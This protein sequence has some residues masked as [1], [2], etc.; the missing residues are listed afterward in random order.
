VAKTGTLE[1]RV[2]RPVAPAKPVPPPVQSTLEAEEIKIPAW[3]EPL[4]RN[5]A[6]PAPPEVEGKDEPVAVEEP[7]RVDAAD[8]PIAPVIRKT[9][10]TAKPA[11]PAAPVFSRTLLDESSA[12]PAK[13]ASGGNKSFLIV[14]AAAVILV[15]AAGGTWYARQSSGSAQNVSPVSAAPAASS[16]ANTSADVSSSQPTAR[17]ASLEVPPSRPESNAVPEIPASVSPSG[18][19]KAQPAILSERIAKTSPSNES[20]KAA[21]KSPEPE[22]EPSKPSLGEV[23]LAKPKMNRSGRNAAAGV[24]E[25]TLEA[26]GDPALDGAAFGGGLLAEGSAQPM[27]PAAPLVVGGDV[28]PARLISSVPPIYPSLAKTQHISG[29]VRVDAL[30][31]ANGRVSAMKVVSGPT[32]LHQAAMDALRQWKYQPANLDGKT[33]AMRLTVT[34]QFRLQ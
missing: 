16:P 15:L 31:D 34:I 1:A 18:R 12:K 4:A 33:V 20:A 17:S 5:A 32:L 21:S 30:I 7:K 26:S 13:A 6:I 27:A 25:P 10:S 3:L 11:R 2:A 8:A 14:A 28:K 29:D 19:P 23:R 9:A 24:A 22:A